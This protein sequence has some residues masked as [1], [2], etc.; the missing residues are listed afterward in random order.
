MTMG[1]L[2]L[3]HHPCELI[4]KKYRDQHGTCV[5]KYKTFAAEPGVPELLQLYKDVYNYDPRTGRP[6]RYSRITPESMKQYKYD[7]ALFYKTFTGKSLP[8]DI[9]RFSQIKLKDYSCRYDPRIKCPGSPPT[10]RENY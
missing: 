3:I 5:T 2:Q 10:T 9:T 8:S 7:L 1:H 4:Q 6:G